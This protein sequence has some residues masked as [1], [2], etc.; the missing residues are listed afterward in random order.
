MQTNVRHSSGFV[1]LCTVNAV[2]IEGG[3]LCSVV[4]IACSQFQI[5]KPVVH[6]HVVTLREWIKA[7]SCA[8]SEW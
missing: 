5:A 3:R 6:Y 2:L 1:S 4:L 7:P 8:P